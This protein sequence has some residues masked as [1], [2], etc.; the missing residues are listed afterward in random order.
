M[1]NDNIKSQK[2]LESLNRKC[3]YCQN[4][5]ASVKCKVEDCESWYHYPC[6]VA[7]GAFQDQGDET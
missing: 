2:V 1:Y 3:K 5:G 6:V 4:Y 7:S